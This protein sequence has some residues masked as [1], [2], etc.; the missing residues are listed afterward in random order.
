MISETVAVRYE[1]NSSSKSSSIIFIRYFSPLIKISLISIDLN[2]I[3]KFLIDYKFELIYLEFVIFFYLLRDKTL[4]LV[5]KDHYTVK[6][7]LALFV[8]SYTNKHF[9]YNLVWCNNNL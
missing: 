3:G 5:K 9:E 8:L 2:I 6:R 1:I 7:N 4:L